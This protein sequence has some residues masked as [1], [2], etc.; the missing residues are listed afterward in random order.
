MTWKAAINEAYASAPA[1][2]VTLNTIELRHPTFKDANGLPTAIWVVLDPNPLTARLEASAVINPGQLVTFT[3]F[4]FD[5]KLPDVTE[6]GNCDLTISIDNVSLE[7]RDAL[8]GTLGGLDPIHVTYRPYLW[9]SD[10]GALTPDDYP[11]M[12]P[13]IVLIAEKVTLDLQ[14]CTMTCL[15]GDMKNKKFPAV[16]YTAANFPNLVV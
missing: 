3:P 10:A 1:H 14:K 6:D 8:E 15:F 12:D 4:A 16:L 9:D 5:F 7:I 2:L 11:Q 13:P